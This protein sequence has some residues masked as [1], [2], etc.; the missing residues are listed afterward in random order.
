MK[1]T[2][3]VVASMTACTL[4][5]DVIP[6]GEAPNAPDAGTNSGEGYDPAFAANC[7]APDGPVHAYTTAEEV[8][9]LLTAQ[10]AYCS[11]D[12]LNGST[13]AGISFGSDGIY[14]DLE[15]W[16]SDNTLVTSAGTSADTWALDQVAANEVELLVTT[17]FSDKNLD[18]VWSVTFED[19]PRKLI[20]KDQAESQP[21][22]YAI[23]Q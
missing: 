10:W 11:G 6:V 15:A 16:G 4:N 17:A 1:L 23:I 3:L 5:N 2:L 13:Q 9:Q 14:L 12:V 20:V 18:E 7:A 22:I 21:S 8:A 19:S